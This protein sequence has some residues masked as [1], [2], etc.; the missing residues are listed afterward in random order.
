MTQ[1]QQYPRLRTTWTLLLVRYIPSFLFLGG[2]PKPEPRNEIRMDMHISSKLISKIIDDL[3]NMYFNEV[4]A[5]MDPHWLVYFPHHEQEVSSRNPETRSE[6][7]Y[8]WKTSSNAKSFLPCTA[9]N[10]S[11][12]ESSSL[13]TR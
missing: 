10:S 4:V 12:S 2:D 6:A 7:T 3:E 9:V 13:P 11:S 5:R 1:P 8:N